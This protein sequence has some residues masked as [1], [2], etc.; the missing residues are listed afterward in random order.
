MYIIYKYFRTMNTIPTARPRLRPRINT[1]TDEVMRRPDYTTTVIT[2]RSAMPEA[3]IKSSAAQPSLT[4]R[5][6]PL[7]RIILHHSKWNEDDNKVIAQKVKFSVPILTL[8]DCEK[9]VRHAFTYG[10]SIV[11]TVTKDKAELYKEALVRMG[12]NATME[13]A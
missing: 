13:E 12:L 5:F 2:N 11:C 4:L 6:E 3:P 8:R 9:V 1:R 7:Y 10:M